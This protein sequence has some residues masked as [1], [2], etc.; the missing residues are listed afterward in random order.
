MHLVQQARDF[1]TLADLLRDTATL[2]PHTELVV[3]IEHDEGD[4][5]SEHYTCEA[6][7]HAVEHV[8]STVHEVV[9]EVAGHGRRA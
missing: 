1:M 3:R 7:L 4:Y 9:L 2:P 5:G 8:R 6:R